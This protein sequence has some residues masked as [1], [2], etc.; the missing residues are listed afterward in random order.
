MVVLGIVLPTV[1]IDF[2][3]VV[4]LLVAPIAVWIV[5]LAIAFLEFPC[6]G[7]YFSIKSRITFDG[8]L[9]S[10]CKLLRFRGL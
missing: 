3:S 6:Y 10:R 8:I 2:L 7:L 1:T 9:R 5:L 4:L